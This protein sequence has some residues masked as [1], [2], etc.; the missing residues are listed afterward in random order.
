MSL[1]SYSNAFTVNSRVSLTTNKHVASMS[2][3]KK[4]SFLSMSSEDE[5]I[6]EKNTIMKSVNK[7]ILY[8]EKS[9]RFFESEEECNPQ[10]E[11]CVVD[12]KTGEMIRLTLEEKERIFL[13]SLQSYY[14]N[15]KQM[16]SDSEFDLLKADLQ[17]SGSAK[18]NVNRKE[19]K[20]V[21]S[22]QAYLKDEPILSDEEFDTLKR[23]L[24][25]EGSQ[26]AVSTE[27]KCYISTG[28]CTVTWKE[29]EFRQNLLFLPLG[30]ITT[31][32][33]LGFGYE[34][35]GAVVKINPLVLLLFGAY[36]IYV[37][38]EQLTN[39]FIFQDAKVARGLC[40][41]CESPQRVYFGNILGVEGFDKTSQTKCTNCKVTYQVQKKSLRAST[42]PK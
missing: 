6:D 10:D 27:P 8:D 2:P 40:P 17:W 5:E 21:A 30:A 32:L 39:S 11:Y 26:F 13:D 3:N 12:Q 1:S 37:G 9:G 28:I 41:A 31:L 42:L 18:V 19:A 14:I 22:M 16:L 36:P 38:T 24:K 20:Y 33:W 15:G 29:D 25:E 34:I 7:E 4:V 35:L 23:E